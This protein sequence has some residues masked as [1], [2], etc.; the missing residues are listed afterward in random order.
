MSRRQRPPVTYAQA[1]AIWRHRLDAHREANA[2][3]MRRVAAASGLIGEKVAG[4]RES[5]QGVTALSAQP[6]R[7]IS[8]V[9][10][11]LTA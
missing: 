8:A 3:A 6:G 4:T 10:H 2:A 7:P 1:L 9:R 11:G 5:A